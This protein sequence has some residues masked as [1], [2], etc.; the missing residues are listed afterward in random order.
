MGLRRE[1]EIRPRDPLLTTRWF[2]VSCVTL[3]I[4]YALWALASMIAR[5]PTFK[6]VQAPSWYE[7][8]WSMMI[9]LSALTAGL[10]GASIFFRVPRIRQVTK[11]RI[12]RDALAIFC[13]TIAI[14]HA[15]VGLVAFSGDGSRF[16][17]FFITFSYYIMPVFRMYH[18]NRRIRA[19]AGQS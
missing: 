13:G 16:A 12:E 2:D 8:S 6:I 14:Y 11:K 15:I 7:I 3:W 9:L 19:L 5:I 10:A 4:T 1:S 17:L 18:L